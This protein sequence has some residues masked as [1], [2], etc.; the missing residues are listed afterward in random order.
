MN[1]FV[2]IWVAVGVFTGGRLLQSQETRGQIFGRVS[3][4]SSAAVTGAS[5]EITNVDTNTTVKLE[6]NS[7][8]YYEANLLL[9]GNYQVTVEAAGFKRHVR[10]G[11][12]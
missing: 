6:T 11:L 7:T 1:R 2:V 10:S 3:D 8:G 9:P 12:V 4:Q 5:V